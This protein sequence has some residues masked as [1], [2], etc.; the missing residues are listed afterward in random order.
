MPLQYEVFVSQLFEL[1][2]ATRYTSIQISEYQQCT[3]ISYEYNTF[4]LVE[5]SK[6]QCQK[7][8]IHR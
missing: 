7:N 5:P 3:L 6:E 4:I 1:L 2:I 8:L